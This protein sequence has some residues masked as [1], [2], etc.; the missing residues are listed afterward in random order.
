MSHTHLS[1]HPSERSTAPTSHCVD[2]SSVQHLL[3]YELA[4]A[5]ITSKAAFFKFVGDPLDLRP[6]EFTILMLVR[7]TPGVT[8][9]QL[10]KVLLVSAPNVT[11]LLDRLSAK[12]WVERTRSDVD[13]RVQKVSLS[14]EG[15]RLADEAHRL[16]L[17]CEHEM[18]RHLS[19]GERTLLMELLRRINGHRPR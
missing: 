1:A 12:G 19:I 10:A 11:L 17:G 7:S 14:A 3:G 15:R 8:Q 16:S 9:K 2:Q 6:V 18:L 4:L 13:R 5:D